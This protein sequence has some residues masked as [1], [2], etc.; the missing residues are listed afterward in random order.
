MRHFNIRKNHYFCPIIN[1]D[2][3]WSLVGHEVRGPLADAP[4]GPAGVLVEIAWERSHA[5]DKCAAVPAV[6]DAH[7]APLAGCAPRLLRSERAQPSLTCCHCQ[8]RCTG[9]GRDLAARCL[10][11]PAARPQPAPCPRR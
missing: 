7:A 8:C 1:L 11:Q 2:K 6:R 3:L 10:P 5:A 4:A 9:S